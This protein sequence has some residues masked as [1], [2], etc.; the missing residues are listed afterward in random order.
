MW[1]LIDIIL[2]LLQLVFDHLNSKGREGTGKYSHI[3]TLFS[4][5]E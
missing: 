3:Q 5:S 2:S 4:K 1:D